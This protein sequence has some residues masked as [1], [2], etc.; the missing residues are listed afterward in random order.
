MTAN[1]TR[2]GFLALL[3]CAAGAALLPAGGCAHTAAP[4]ATPVGVPPL[5]AWDNSEILRTGRWAG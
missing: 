1:L 4:T 3:V 2:R 5:R